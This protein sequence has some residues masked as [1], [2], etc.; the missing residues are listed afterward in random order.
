M[1]ESEEYQNRQEVRYGKEVASAIEN[2]NERIGQLKTKHSEFLKNSGI[3][4]DNNFV[5]IFSAHDASYNILNEEIINV[6]GED[7]KKAYDL[8][9]SELLK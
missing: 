9:F 8:S 1:T 7:I 6:M 4:F 5:S 3:D 2:F